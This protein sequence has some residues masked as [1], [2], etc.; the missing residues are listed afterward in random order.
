VSN[1]EPTMM[2]KLSRAITIAAIALAGSASVAL[3][4]HSFSMFDPE[5]EVVI[6][7]EVVRWNFTSPHT[8]MLIKDADGKV[9]AFEG[10]APPGLLTRSPA[11]TGDSFK[12]GDQI[13]VVMCPLRDGRAGGA[14][15]VFVAADGTAYNPS[16][17]GC[18]ANQRIKEW[19]AWI[20]KGYNNLVEAKAGEG[21]E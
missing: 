20:E 12:A 3:A 18:R 14:A 1:K 9:W 4:H 2:K 13:S 8:F 5:Q 16:D 7:G 15:G 10:S 11:M 17:A 6:K 19:P 21:I